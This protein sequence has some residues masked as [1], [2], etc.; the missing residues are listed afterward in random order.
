MLNVKIPGDMLKKL[1]KATKDAG[2]KLPSEMATVLNAVAKKTKTE[3]SKQVRQELAAPAKA[4]NETLSQS[5]KASQGQLGATV[6]LSKTK[7]IPLRDFGARQTKLGV[8]YKTSKTEGRRFVASAFQGPKPGLMK[9]SWRGR[10]FKRVDKSRLPIVQLFGPSPW[11]VFVK[12]KMTRKTI[13]DT[14]KEL[15]KQMDKRIKFL[16]L[17]STGAI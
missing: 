8:S 4:V 15:T 1:E 13:A 11:G 2:R 5:R 9:A 3:M 16:I 12:R 14:E 17:K 6:T 7:R 10:V